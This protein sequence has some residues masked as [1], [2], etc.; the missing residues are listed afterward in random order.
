[1]KLTYVICEYDK[2][3][4]TI[5]KF[6]TVMQNLESA[7]IAKARKDWPSL[8]YTSPGMNPKSGE[9]GKSTVMPQLF[10]NMSGVRLVTWNQLLTATGH[11]TVMTG[12]AAA[13]TIAE[14]YKVG[15]C[16]L[17]ILDKTMRI[18][19]IKMQISD[20]KLPR[21]NLEEAM[22]YERPAIVFEEAFI[23]DEETG[24]DL[25]AYVECPG[26]QRIMP[27]GLQ[28][29]RVPNKLQVSNPGAALQ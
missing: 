6:S 9:F 24:F 16:G 2:V 23:L 25:Y 27:I 13:S 15:L 28:V 17:A 10:N 3:R 18:T 4:E 14:D 1:M 12:A 5:P 29:N 22:A 21:I 7:L 11:Q 20:R 8:G 26:P 19:E